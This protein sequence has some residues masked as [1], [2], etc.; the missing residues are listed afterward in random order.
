MTVARSKQASSWCRRKMNVP[1]RS[2][3]QTW[4][5]LGNTHRFRA[6]FGFGKSGKHP[7]VCRFLRAQMISTYGKLLA[8]AYPLSE[9]RVSGSRAR[10]GQDR[11]GC[12]ARS[13]WTFCRGGPSRLGWRRMAAVSISRINGEIL[14]ASCRLGPHLEH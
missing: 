13:N 2:G 6:K 4:A 12:E 9:G 1:Q 5:E 10:G 8:D 3:P 14:P 7:G 11:T